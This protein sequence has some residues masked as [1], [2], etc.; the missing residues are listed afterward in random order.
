MVRCRICGKPTGIGKPLGGDIVLCADHYFMSAV[1]QVP[2]LSPDLVRRKL[3]EQM[4]GKRASKAGHE[5][6][7]YTYLSNDDDDDGW[8][9]CDI[10]EARR[11]ASH[12]PH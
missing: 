7:P 6:W 1:K 8:H 11:P 2:S 4:R 10:C 5:I 12:F 3:D 9:Y